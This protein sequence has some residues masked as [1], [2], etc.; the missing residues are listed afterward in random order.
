MGTKIC[1]NGPWMVPFQNC[2]RWTHSLSKMAA[3]S[4]HSFKDDPMGKT[5]KNLLV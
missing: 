2:I 5:M 3:V 4:G 1:G